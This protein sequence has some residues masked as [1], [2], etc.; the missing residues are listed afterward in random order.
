MQHGG[1][2]G[3]EEP[4]AITS[5]CPSRSAKSSWRRGLNHGDCSQA[6]RS[7]AASLSEALVK[8]KESVETP[9][10]LGSSRSPLVCSRYLQ[11]D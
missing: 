11:Q 8:L 5:G 7:E 9:P 6:E 2:V 3:K 10:K 1:Q 4:E